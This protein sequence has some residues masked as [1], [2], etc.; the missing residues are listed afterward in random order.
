MLKKI[1]FYIFT[2]VLASGAFAYSELKFGV[3]SINFD[4]PGLQGDASQVYVNY[5]GYTEGN[6][7]YGVGYRFYE[8]DLI[9]SGF[10]YPIEVGVLDGT[11]GYAFQD[12][13]DG[14]FYF[15]ARYSTLSVSVDGVNYDAYVDTTG[16][17]ASFGYMKQSNEGTNWNIQLQFDID[18]CNVDCEVLGGGVDFPI[19]DSIWNFGFELAFQED[20]TSLRIGP[21]VKF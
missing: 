5:N 15:Q 2:S 19:P 12:I 6:V 7:M 14:G 1:I 10:I 11:V 8:T 4:S 3:G 21:V 13:S 9:D 16:I 18:D 17:F 20:T